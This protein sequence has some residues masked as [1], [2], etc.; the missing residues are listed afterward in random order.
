MLSTPDS[1]EALGESF[2]LS[3]YGC[4]LKQHSFPRQTSIQSGE[5]RFIQRL[6]SHDCSSCEC[7]LMTNWYLDLQFLYSCKRG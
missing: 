5:Y 6:G 1:A 7:Y 3:V 2:I 4:L